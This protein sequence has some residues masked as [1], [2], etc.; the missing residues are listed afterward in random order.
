M[1]TS[2][3]VLVNGPASSAVGAGTFFAAVLLSGF[4]RFFARSGFVSGLYSVVSGT[5][6]LVFVGFVGYVVSGAPFRSAF[7]YVVAI[8][9][10]ILSPLGSGW[11]LG[12]IL[13]SISRLVGRVAVTRAQP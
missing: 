9:A 1:E 10:F 8:W 5:I 7:G 11:I 12:L 6:I 2:W 3:E 13:G 4:F